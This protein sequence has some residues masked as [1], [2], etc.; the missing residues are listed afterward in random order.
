M[1]K[2]LRQDSPQENVMTATLTI[3]DDYLRAMEDRIVER[4][5]EKLKAVY[6]D[7]KS[8]EAILTVET[9]AQYLQV[10]V[11]W[12]YKSVSLNSIPFFKV[13]KYTRF[14]KKKIDE[15]IEKHAVKV[16]PKS[17]LKNVA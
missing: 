6:N 4:L 3:P 8:E 15:W 11:S 2:Q 17:V 12:V 16:V 10:D 14:H 5:F 9:L 7:R 13:G 1:T